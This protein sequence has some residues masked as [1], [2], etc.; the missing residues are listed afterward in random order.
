MQR[1]DR[2]RHAHVRVAEP[3][4]CASALAGVL[5]VAA[6]ACGSSATH[7]PDAGGLDTPP[8]QWTWVPIEGTTCGNGTVAGIGVN[9]LAG[10]RDLFVYFEGGGACWDLGTCFALKTA[11]NID[12]TYDA[13]HFQADIASFDLQRAGT[14]FANAV[15]VVVPYCTGDLHA[16]THVSMYDAS[17]VVHHTGGT[18][19][20]AFIDALAATWPSLDHVW[21]AGSSAG[22]Y[23]GTLNLHRFAAAWPQAE[24]HLLQ[25]S[26]PFV[27]PLANYPTWQSD[28]SLQFPPGCTDCASSFP[29]VV[30]TVATSNPQS[31]IGL[32]TYDDDAVVKAFFSYSGSLVPA[33]DALLASQYSHPN[34]KAFVLAG[35]SH[36]MLGQLATLVGPGGVHLS[37]WVTQWATGDPAWATVR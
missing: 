24:V 23:G 5:V 13:A 7:A 34:T 6:A 8:G 22:G 10:A 17:H 2:W 21:V 26:S 20:Q 25:D 11:I 32:L 9:A 37:D 28:W 19:T 35:T 29:A 15:M 4:R 12:V 3:T 36:T 33:T 16:G 14:P 30:D 27:P 1:P 18:N 31:R